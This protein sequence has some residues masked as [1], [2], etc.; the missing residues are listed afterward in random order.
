MNLELYRV[1]CCVVTNGNIL[2]AS[3]QLFI[4]IQVSSQNNKTI[5]NSFLLP[6]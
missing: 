5:K 6:I 1:F 4:S 2:K 3:E